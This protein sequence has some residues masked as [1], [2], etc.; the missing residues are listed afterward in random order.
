M[1]SQKIIN[2]LD[3]T[4]DQ[5]CATKIY[6]DNAISAFNSDRIESV[7]GNTNV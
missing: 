6:V 2:V 5:D 4:L 3:P 7:S 1:N